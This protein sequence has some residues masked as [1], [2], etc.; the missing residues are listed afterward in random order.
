M[1]LVENL[2]N[3]YHDFSIDIPHWEILDEG[4]TVL[5][6]ASGAGKTSIFRSLLGLEKLE[7]GFTWKFKDIDLAS[8]PVGERKLGVVFQSYELFPHMTGYQNIEFAA[9]CRKIPDIEFRTKIAS[10]SKKLNMQSFME[11]PAAVLSGGER[12][13][14]ALARALIANP[15][16]LMLDEPFS[17]L[18]E[19]LKQESR[20]LVNAVLRDEKIPVLMITHDQRDVDV[21]ADK[22]SVLRDGRIIEEKMK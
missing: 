12:Q 18:D 4:V 9:Q 10:L 6:G 19:S 5:W 22:V 2:H 13:R 3:K 21:M 17:A 7:S 15:R 16:L 11:R 1:S 14:V 20:E 8:L